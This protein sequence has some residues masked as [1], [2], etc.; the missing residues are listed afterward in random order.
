[1]FTHQ[2][3]TNQSAG[4][5]SLSLALHVD[6][7]LFYLPT[8]QHHQLTRLLSDFISKKMSTGPSQA[9]LEAKAKGMKSVTTK[10]AS[11]A[12][13]A[14]LAAMEKLYSDNGGDLAK[15][16]SATGIA[17]KPNAVVK[18]AKDFAVKMCAG[19]ITTD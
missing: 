1:L 8:I 17:F 4:E 10:T 15:I 19:L 14:A 12:D 13:P 9:D 3:I 6:L 2:H 16:T 5:S 18:D 11:G 7:Q